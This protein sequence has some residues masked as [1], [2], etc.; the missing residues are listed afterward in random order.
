MS[1]RQVF[2]A[3]IPYDI[4]IADEKYYQSTFL[5][6]FRMLNLH[7]EAEAR[8]NIG[9]IDAVVQ[10]VQR[11]YIFEFKLDGSAENVM[12]Q[13]KDKSYY[14]KFLASGKEIILIGANFSTE[15]RRVEKWRSET[16]TK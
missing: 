12:Q 11:I 2:F 7:I 13:I 10:T 15:K 6:V 1:R 8:T 3:G 4:Q 14:E 9:R 16:I 5:I